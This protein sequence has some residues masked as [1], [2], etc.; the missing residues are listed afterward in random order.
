MR[1]A[2]L[3]ACG[4]LVVLWASAEGLPPGIAGPVT[5]RHVVNMVLYALFVGATYL[6][7]HW[8][9]DAVTRCGHRLLDR[10]GKLRRRP[11]RKL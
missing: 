2:V 4:A 7:A 9:G 5:V 11:W 8:L 6:G 1:D 10:L 3:V